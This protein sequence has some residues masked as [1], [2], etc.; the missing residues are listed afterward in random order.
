MHCCLAWGY[1]LRDAADVGGVD[2]CSDSYAAGV[3][4]SFALGAGRLA[5]AAAAKGISLAASSRAAASAGRQQLK[6]L[7]RV[8]AGKNW[9]LPN[10]E[11]LSDAALQASAGRM[12]P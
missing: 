4:S 9:R 7:Y 2:M 1:E 5:S 10:V 3:W 11:G 6:N 8:G 12:N